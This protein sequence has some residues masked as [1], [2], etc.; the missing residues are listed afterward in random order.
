MNVGKCKKRMKKCILL[1]KSTDGIH[2][3][4]VGK[5]HFLDKKSNKRKHTLG[6]NVS[7]SQKDKKR[8]KKMLNI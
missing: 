8:I 3:K 4:K 1:S 5:N 2:H 6:K 7:F